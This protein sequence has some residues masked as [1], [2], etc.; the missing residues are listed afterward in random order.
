MQLLL[1][2]SGGREHALAW[3]LA[4]D[5]RVTRIFVAPGNAGTAREAK[6]ENLPIDAEDQEALLAFAKA[7]AIT[8]T[9][10]GP[11]A[12]LVAGIVDRFE[13]AGLKILGP[14][15][16]AARLEGSKCFSKAFMQ[17]A[18]IPTAAAA[19]FTEL[20]P[21]LDYLA[22]R[23]FPQ[24]IKADGLAAGKGVSVVHNLI[25]GEAMLRALLVD[26]QF[27][28]AGQQL[29]IEAFLPGSELSYIVLAD[30]EQFVPLASS[31]DHKPVG[32]GDTGPNT[33]GM[34][35]YSPAPICTPDVE[36][37][38][39]ERILQPTL[40]GLKRAGYAY[41]G[42]LYLGLMIDDD[43]NPH[44]VE[45]NCR[46]GDPET[47][48][49]L[50]RLDSSLLDLCLAA[51][52]GTLAEQSPVWHAASA[53]GVVLASAG[54]PASCQK[55]LPIAPLPP[56]GHGEKL[57]FAGVTE[58]EQCLLTAGGRVFCAT[59][60]GQ[61]LREARQNAYRLADQVRFAGA[62][63]R[64]DIGTRPSRDVH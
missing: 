1:I 39:V 21:A 14:C 49:I 48:P 50:M 7:Q 36:Q 33:G 10:V 5:P 11:E 4:E 20:E 56:I 18:A 35:A 59:A 44:V 41:R 19:S 60:R 37:R 47:Q 25:E 34:G 54:Y 40:A 31:Q 2:G 55:G 62:F 16:A 12:P 51:L 52:D 53:L 9:V 26:R 3:K 17:A 28:T 27:G 43:D 38:I 45:Y 63:C 29:L 13:A 58:R 8:L 23:P 57:F 46:L 22:A 32:E 42:F 30:G 6:C 24:V 64:R 15:A 61:T